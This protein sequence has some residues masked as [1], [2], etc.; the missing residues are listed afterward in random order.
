MKTLEIP[1]DGLEGLKQNWTADALSGFLVFLLAMPL[2]LGIAKASGFP[3]AMGVL[4][5]MIGGL[6][7]SI[8]MGGRLTIKGP[9]AGLITVCAGA[10]TDLGKLNID[11]VSGV[12]LACGA[13]IVMSVIQ[14]IL[15]FLKFGSFSDFFP[16]SAV[17]GMLAAIGVLIF[18]KQF[19]VLLGVDA[20][21]TK[22]LTPIELYTHIPTFIENAHPEI[23]TIGLLS[24]AI[25]FGLPAMGGIFKKIPAPMIVLILTI[26]L[27]IYFNFNEILDASGKPFALVHI[28]DFWSGVKFNAS[29]AA[30][31]SGTFWYYV[32]MF[33]FVNSLESLLTVKAIDGLDPWK[34]KSDY[35]TDLK[36][37]ALGNGVSGALGGL[38]MISEVARSSANVNFGARTRWANFF[39][40]LCLLIAMLLLIPVINLI[41]NAALAAM[42]IAVAYRLASPKEFIGTYKIG[43]EQLVIFLTTIAVTVAEDLLLGIAAGI[44]VKFIFH[45]INGAPFGSLFKANHEVKETSEGYTINVKQSAIF[46]NLMGFQKMWTNLKTGKKITFNFAETKL[47]DHTF[48]EALHHFE[49][50]YHNT[51]GEVILAGLSKHKG[52][53]QHPMA[54]RKLT[55]GA[56]H[57]L[58]IELSPRAEELESFAE[59][60]GYN[61]YPQKVK[62]GLKYK[63]FPIQKGSTLR[64]EENLMEKYSENAKIEISD[65][66]VTE[67]LLSATE[68]TH[69]T[70]IHLSDTDLAIPD[71]ALEPESL[72]TK[73]SEVSGG[74][75][76]DFKEH[77][78]FSKTYYLR[79]DDEQ[80][81]RNFFS[82]SIIQFLESHEEMHIECHK[83]RLLIF[84]Q[85]DLMTPAEIDAAVKFSEAFVEA[86]AKKLG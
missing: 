9:A 11:G 67:I 70:V 41:P 40:G 22:G 53:S 57:S 15:G 61:F 47:V 86:A 10:V 75:D 81:V 54:S 26:P 34:R 76:I 52:L 16:H 84:K 5:A 21:F 23:A 31:G 80:S 20:S 24:L 14:V 50:D 62:T 38:P 28:V 37:L 33:L 29:F 19:P 39:H 82:G 78:E 71:F 59:S 85:R 68:D 3:A 25:L 30:L 74:K 6:V 44:I 7:V 17:H 36:A 55:R 46:S 2:S 77:P 63:N 66:T 32:F 8:F 27:G 48:Q 49:E 83:H 56:A 12:Q 69:I 72:H 4:T 43:P 73:L 18:A 51:G 42:L 13:V 64:Y 79:G 58:V 45:L 1:K 65:I 60:G 35:N